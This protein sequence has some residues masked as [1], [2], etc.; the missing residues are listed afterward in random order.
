DPDV[1][2]LPIGSEHTR[3]FGD[4][5][6]KAV[7]IRVDERRHGQRDRP[8][9]QGECGSVG[10]NHHRAVVCDPKLIG[11]QVYSDGLKPARLKRAEVQAGAAPDVEDDASWLDELSGA[12]GKKASEGLQEVAR[13]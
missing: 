4:C 12:R 11:G 5:G 3:D 6:R 2:E 9:S 10:L 1:H 7:D 8:A 13:Y